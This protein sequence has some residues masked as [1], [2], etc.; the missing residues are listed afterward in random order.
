MVLR[1][2]HAYLAVLLAVHRRLRERLDRHLLAVLDALSQVHA[3]EVALADLLEHLEHL[4]E[5]ELVD[6]APAEVAEPLQ[7]GPD[8]LV[9]LVVAVHA[10]LDRG[11]LAHLGNVLGLE[12]LGLGALGLRARLER[13]WLT[14]HL[15]LGVEGKRE[16]LV[17][18]VEVGSL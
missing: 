9:H 14:Q 1:S 3:R 18:P 13:G 16:Q 5:P 15:E 10:E 2:L 8:H 7:V 11:D 17:W 12:L 4:V 6:L